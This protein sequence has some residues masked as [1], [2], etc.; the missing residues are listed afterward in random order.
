MLM[1]KSDEPLASA[2]V[3]P[4]AS[5]DDKYRKTTTNERKS[6]VYSANVFSDSI[7]NESGSRQN[8]SHLVTH[9]RTARRSMSHVSL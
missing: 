6:V 7:G 2:A 4:Q 8:H 3:M 5:A 9:Q 1:S